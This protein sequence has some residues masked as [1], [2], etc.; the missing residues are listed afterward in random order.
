MP[1]LDGVKKLKSYDLKIGRKER[2]E[3]CRKED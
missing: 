1:Q 3:I 2:K